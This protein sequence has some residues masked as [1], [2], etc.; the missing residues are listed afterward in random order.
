MQSWS[1]D[2]SNLPVKTLEYILIV[3]CYIL[4][5]TL[6]FKYRLK[7][8]QYKNTILYMFTFV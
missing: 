1:S 7:I 2:F 8:I 4:C 3:D 5:A 6:F